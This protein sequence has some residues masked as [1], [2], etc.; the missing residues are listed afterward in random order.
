M[1]VDGGWRVWA[2]FCRR[3]CAIYPDVQRNGRRSLGLGI[4]NHRRV[5]PGED[6]VASV[7]A[8]KVRRHRRDAGQSDIVSLAA[9]NY[10]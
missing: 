10:M 9:H 1:V 7:H 2:K 6:A 5:A 4:Y 3:E 8:H